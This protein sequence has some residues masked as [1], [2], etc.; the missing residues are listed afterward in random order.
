MPPAPKPAPAIRPVPK[1]G[2]VKD[3]AYLAHV[4][5]LPCRVASRHHECG[6]T[7]GKGPSEVS[8]LAG[9]NRDDR[10]IPLC[11]VAHRTGRFAWHAGQR[12][13]LMYYGLTK[14][15][16]IAEAEAMYA[17]WKLNNAR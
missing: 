16:L 11:G 5:T 8:H 15:G 10:V 4:R 13:F 3:P 9:R 7:M 17:D 2:K 12:T 6:D 1:E 14:A